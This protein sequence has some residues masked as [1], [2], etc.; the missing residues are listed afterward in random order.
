MKRLQEQTEKEKQMLVRNMEIIAR[1][2]KAPAEMI[3]TLQK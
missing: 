3:R 1:Q 2:V